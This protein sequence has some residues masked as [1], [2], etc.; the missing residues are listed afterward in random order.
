MTQ[1]LNIKIEITP[2]SSTNYF[3]LD[4]FSTLKQGV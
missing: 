2:L 4:T 1:T 3:E